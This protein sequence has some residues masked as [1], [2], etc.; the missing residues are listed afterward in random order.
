VL[1]VSMGSDQ[2]LPPHQTGL[3]GSDSSSG[4]DLP[5]SG[6]LRRE[7][8]APVAGVLSLITALYFYPHLPAYVP[9]LWSAGNPV[10]AYNSRGWVA[11]FPVGL[12]VVLT[13]LFLSLSNSEL[14]TPSSRAAALSLWRTHRWLRGSVLFALWWMQFTRLNLAA[15]PAIRLPHRPL[16]S[17]AGIVAL[18]LCFALGEARASHSQDEQSPSDSEKHGT[19]ASGSD[20]EHSTLS[21]EE[22]G[23][24]SGSGRRRSLRWALAILGLVLLGLALR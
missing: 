9:D 2:R 21:R 19:E 4:S 23:V 3:S 14:R 10:D 1:A 20:R 15:P 5:W 8:L 16:L 22:A 18:L 6:R 7:W 11:F 24:R 17:G 13:L 12:N